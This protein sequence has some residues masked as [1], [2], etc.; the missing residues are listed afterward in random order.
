MSFELH[1]RYSEPMPAFISAPIPELFQRFNPEV[2]LVSALGFL[3]HSS[4]RAHLGPQNIIVILNS[5]NFLHPNFGS[6]RIVR[7]SQFLSVC[8]VLLPFLLHCNDPSSGTMGFPV[9]CLILE[10]QPG[11]RS[12]LLLFWI[13]NKICDLYPHK[14]FA[15]GVDE[16]DRQMVRGGFHM[17]SWTIESLFPVLLKGLPSARKFSLCSAWQE[18]HYFISY[19]FSTYGLQ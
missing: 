15:P 19:S 17:K 4:R 9:R 13:H 12:N 16:L 8:S 10:F 1:P 14:K 6:P 3:L 18:N 5:Y 7:P 11:M 2:S